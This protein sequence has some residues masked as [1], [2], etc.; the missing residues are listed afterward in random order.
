MYSYRQHGG[1][2][3]PLEAI[4]GIVSSWLQL[5]HTATLDT[6][7]IRPYLCTAKGRAQRCHIW[8][9]VLTSNIDTMHLKMYIMVIICEIIL[10]VVTNILFFKYNRFKQK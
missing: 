6:I 1:L 8:S 5:L 3:E 4:T 9:T 7:H 10:R 2:Q